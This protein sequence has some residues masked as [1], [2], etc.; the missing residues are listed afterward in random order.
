MPKQNIKYNQPPPGMRRVA[1]QSS[2]SWMSRNVRTRSSP[3]PQGA[4][5]GASEN[6]TGPTQAQSLQNAAELTENNANRS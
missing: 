4:K 6:C 3:V 2:F 1:K 5:T